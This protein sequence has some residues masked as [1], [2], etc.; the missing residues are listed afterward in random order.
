MPLIEVSRGHRQTGSRLFTR[1]SGKKIELITVLPW[2]HW[3]MVSVAFE[4]DWNGL[5]GKLNKRDSAAELLQVKILL[6]CGL[7]LNISEIK[8]DF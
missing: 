3:E 4:R 1:A 5:N 2:P 7:I 8:K 6:Q